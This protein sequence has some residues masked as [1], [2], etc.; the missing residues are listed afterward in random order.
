[1]YNCNEVQVVVLMG[2]LGTRLHTINTPKSMVDVN[3]KPFF[4]YQFMLLLKAGFKKFVFLVGYKSEKIEQYFGDGSTYG[5]DISIKYSYDTEKLLGT[6]GAVVNALPLLEDSFLLIY[7]D[8]FMDVDYFEIIYRYFRS[9]KKALMTIM[10]NSDKYDKSNVLYENGRILKYSKNSSD[11]FKHIDYG[12]EIFSKD[13]FYNLPHGE[14]IDLSDCQHNLVENDECATCEETHRFYEIGTPASLQEFKRYSQRRFFEPHGIC[15]IDRDGVINNIVFN[16]NTEQLDSPMSI[17]EFTF[18][19]GAID[20]LKMLSEASFDIYIVTNQPAAAKGKTTLAN[21]YDINHYMIKEL[22]KRGINIT[23]V[24]MCPHH[25][26]GSPKTKE[27]FLVKKCE[28]RKPASAMIKNILSMNKADFNY[29]FM[30]G[31]SYTDILAGKAEGVK[32]AFIGDYKC[33]ICS[34]L[35]YCKPDIISRNLNEVVSLI[36]R[37]KE[38]A[39]K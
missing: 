33:D 1:M 21:L 12:I 37:E 29:T 36:L 10:E 16:E 3:G 4:E 30:I 5:E 27:Q 18:I 8:S 38:N 17:Q 28:C 26:L 13:V 2:G 14:K 22:S 19:D 6:A 32:T 23:G 24:S 9:K 31:D 39:F 34:R 35:N 25:P 7:G 20:A 15:F 11:G